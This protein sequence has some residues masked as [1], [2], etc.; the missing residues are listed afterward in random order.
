MTPAERERAVNYLTQ[1][2]DN[3]L[4]T[5]RGLSR[6]QLQFKSAPDR[7]SGLAMSR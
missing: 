1:S 7:W 2:R 5:I 3:L 6:E 4:R